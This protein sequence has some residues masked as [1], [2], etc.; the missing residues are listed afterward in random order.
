MKLTAQKDLAKEKILHRLWTRNERNKKEIRKI[1]DILVMKKE[2]LEESV[3]EKYAVIERY[4]KELEELGENSRDNIVKFMD[5]SDRQ[6]FHYFERSDQR[7]ENLLEEAAGTLKNYQQQLQED[8]TVEKANRLKKLK[9]TNQLQSWLHKY[10]KD[11]GERTHE[12]K[13]LVAKLNTRQQEYNRWKRNIFDPQEKK[14]FDAMEEKRQIEIREQEER[15]E[16]FMMNRAAKV[17]QRAW[18]SVAERKRKM[19]GKGRGRKGKGK[20]K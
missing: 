15:I 18:R 5:D 20:R 14:Y 16:A 6:M 3:Q 1:E 8:L 2:K 10:D 13:E 7:Y 17:L 11:A 4:R 12:L 19:R 9:L